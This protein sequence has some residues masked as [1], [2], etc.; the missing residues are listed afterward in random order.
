[1]KS[2]DVSSR[3]RL[4]SRCGSGLASELPTAG[5]AIRGQ[6][7]SHSGFVAQSVGVSPLANPGPGS[8]A[9]EQAFQDLVLEL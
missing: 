1:M 2:Q 4:R 5:A 8:G 3:K 7:R 9:I 6:G